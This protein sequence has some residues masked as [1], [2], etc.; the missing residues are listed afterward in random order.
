MRR[1][2]FDGR[3]L[4]VQ[5]LLGVNVIIWGAG[6]AWADE[7]AKPAE[8]KTPPAYVRETFES[9]GKSI[10][11]W[12]FEPNAE[13]KRP[14]VLFL[15]GVDGLE[16]APD[17]YC[18][19]AN[20]ISGQGYVVYL[21]HYLDSMQTK[22]RDSKPLS[23]LVQRGLR[24]T[25]T[26][27]ESQQIREHFRV[28]T[29]CVRDAATHARKQPR[30]DGERVGIVGVSL[31]GFVGLACA[32]QDG[33]KASAVVSCFGGMPSEMRKSVK[34]LPP[35]LVL[36]GDE[37]DLV[38]IQEAI[39]LRKLKRAKK[40][41]IEVVIYPEVGHVF[42]TEDGQFDTKALFDAQRRMTEHLQKHL[43]P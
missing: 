39:E 13:G 42:Q 36:H 5:V 10:R 32:A 15:Y 23:E 35:T 34:K 41:P 37:D 19:V 22:D 24:G 8:G 25:A 29:E 6:L 4:L 27:Q 21:V 26:D 1:S 14:A 11:V 17:V 38:P 18:S 16:V 28:W 20:Q 30:V 33:F 3:R 7:T 43:K 31:G 40:L 2:L 12:R 9:G